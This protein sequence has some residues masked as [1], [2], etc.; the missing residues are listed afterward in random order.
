MDPVPATAISDVDGAKGRIVIR[1]WNLEDLAGSK[2]YEEMC[3]ILWTGKP[4]PMPLGEARAEAARMVGIGDLRSAIASLSTE[5]PVQLTAAM[6]VAA[7]RFEMDT[8]PD[9]ASPH[10]ID[11]LRMASGRAPEP[12]AAKALETYLVTMAENGLNTSTYVARIVASTGAGSPSAIVAALCALEGP[13]HGGAPGLVLDMLEAVGSPGRAEAWVEGELAAGRRIPG[14]GHRIFQ[15]RDP[16]AAILERAVAD[17]APTPRLELARAIERA[18]T[19]ALAARGKPLK[20]NVEFYT[21]VILDAVGIPKALF[22]PT[23]AVA[24]VAGWC[25]HIAEQRAM[26]KLIQP[27]ARYVGPPCSDSEAGL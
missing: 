21:A 26:G 8:A 22:T 4:A 15:G 13:L 2:S 3:G 12:A 14:L 25:A 18:A 19:A 27:N 17:L 7:G 1:G 5:D 10:A 24:R 9:P 6:A 23:F 20:A 16:R 11:Y